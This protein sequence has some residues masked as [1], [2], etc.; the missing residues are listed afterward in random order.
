MGLRT[1]RQSDLAA[2]FYRGRTL[3][4]G[5]RNVFADLLLRKRSTKPAEYLA[6]QRV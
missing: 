6:D 1:H 2:A 4:D 3:P 5:F